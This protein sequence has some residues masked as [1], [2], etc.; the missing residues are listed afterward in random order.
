MNKD[1]I[2]TLLEGVK[3]EAKDLIEEEYSFMVRLWREKG[4]NA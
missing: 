4:V 1:E 2:L 3:E